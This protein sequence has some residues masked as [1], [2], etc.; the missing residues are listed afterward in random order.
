MNSA[1][2]IGID[3]IISKIGPV[4]I[5]WY[6]VMITLAFLTVIGWLVWQ[7][8]RSKLLTSKDLLIVI[9]IV[10]A[11]GVI[12]AKVAH[13]IDFFSYYRQNPGQIF[14][15]FFDGQGW[16]IWGAVLGAVISVWIYSRVSH[17]FS[18]S[19]LL[20]LLAPGIIL[21]QAIGRIGCTINGCCYGITSNSPLAVIYTDP[22]SLAPIGI[23]V[24]PTQV[25]EF[26]FCMA[27][28]AVLLRLRGRLKPDGTLFLVYLTLYAA[29]RLGTDFIR[30]G[31]PFLF[32]LHE[33]Q[34]IAIF[35]LLVAI[36]LIILRV[37]VKSGV[38]L[39]R[40]VAEA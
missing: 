36:P 24:L 4:V 28:F 34:V 10:V 13:I 15:G 32:G 14:T 2:Y 20:D 1:F 22:H 35:V 19:P 39:K 21:G 38:A 40:A 3:P 27:V 33:A 17:K 16:A 6:I 31:T 25:F 18:L 5:S 8:R 29:W 7:N 12:F 37:R 26:F 9:L 23:P 30:V 11:S